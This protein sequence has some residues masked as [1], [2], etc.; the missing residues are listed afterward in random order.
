[1][2]VVD[3]ADVRLGEVGLEDVGAEVGTV[4]GDSAD[5]VVERHRSSRSVNPRHGPVRLSLRD[6]VEDGHHGRGTHT[7]RD[8]DNGYVGCVLHVEENL[9]SRMANL[10]KVALL[11]VVNEKIGDNTRVEGAGAIATSTVHLKTL[12]TLD[13]DTVVVRAGSVTERILAGLEVALISETDLDRDVL[14]GLEGG[15]T[16]AVRGDKIEGPDVIGLFDLFL[17]AE[18]AVTLPLVEFTVE[19]SLTAD[20]HLGKHPVGLCPGLPHLR[21]H[22][23]AKNLSKGVEEVLFDDGIVLGLDA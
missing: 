17:N 13:S 9:A 16:L 18:L 1:M 22:D 15:Q 23:R 11:L 12:V 3:T 6:G 4:A 7:G 21:S 20:E 14:A 5:L 2:V 10:D 19:L 8:E